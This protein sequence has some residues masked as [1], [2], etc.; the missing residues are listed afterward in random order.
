M[1]TVTEIRQSFWE[2][3]PQFKN[4]YRKTYKQN[5]YKTDIRCAFVDYV[6]TLGRCGDISDSLLQRIT[7]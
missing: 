1:K 5:Q 6:D 2:A 4:E 7:L 3:H